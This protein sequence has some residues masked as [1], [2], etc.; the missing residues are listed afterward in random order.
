MRP[1]SVM[2]TSP[3]EMSPSAAAAETPSPCSGWSVT[4]RAGW[5][6]PPSRCTH[7]TRSGGCGARRGEAAAD[8]AE[9]EMLRRPRLLRVSEDE[10]RAEVVAKRVFLAVAGVAP[11]AAAAMGGA[12][13]GC[14]AHGR[15]GTRIGEARV[16]LVWFSCDCKWRFLGRFQSLDCRSAGS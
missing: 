5:T 10:R 3:G 11:A 12:Q 2:R 4:R 6:N 15:G 7:R 8:A 16:E 1:G 9:Q 14:G 13:D